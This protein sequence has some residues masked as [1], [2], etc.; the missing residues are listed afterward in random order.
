MKLSDY[1]F[2]YFT[3]RCFYIPYD[4][5][6]SIAGDFD[7]AESA[8]GLIVYGYVDHEAGL[9]FEILGTGNLDGDYLHFHKGNNKIS[10]KIRSGA[11]KDTDFIY[12]DEEIVPKGLYEDKIRMIDDSYLST[13]SLDVFRTFK[14]LDHLRSPDYPDDFQV[15]LVTEGAKPELVWV[16]AEEVIK[17]EDESKAP[18]FMGTLLN[19]P[20]DPAFGVIKSGTRIPFQIRFNSNDEPMLVTFVQ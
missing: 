10:S 1:N 16:R 15:I 19:D 6:K 7:G 2:R 9:T 13:P 18:Y 4:K 8:T 12:L 20:Y 3:N 5:I 17:P 14:E 11:L